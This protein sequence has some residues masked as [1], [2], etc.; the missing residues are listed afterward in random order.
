MRYQG[1][2]YKMRSILNDIINLNI[3]KD[4]VYVE[5]FVGGCNS[6]AYIDAKHK[7]GSDTNKYVIA[8]WKGLQDASFMPPQQVSKEMYYDVKESW[9]NSDGRYSDAMIGYVAVCCSYGSSWF[10]GYAHYNPKKKE[11]H[12]KEAYNGL[13]KQMNNFKSFDATEFLCRSY[14][15]LEIPE[16]AFI[17][18]DPPYANTKE[19]ANKFDSEVFYQWV[20]DMVAKGHKVMMSEYSAPSD[21]ICIWEKVMQDGMA[22]TNKDKVEKLFIHKSQA[23]DFSLPVYTGKEVA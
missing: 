23:C 7:I 4:T 1:S 6:L 10:G 22:S 12:I 5:P 16:G 2:K 9:K 3:S 8:M 21:F 19:Y 20:R 14:N 17:Y 11:D 15:E 18:C 13:M